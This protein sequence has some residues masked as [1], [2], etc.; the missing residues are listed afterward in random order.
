VVEA[1]Q[2]GG[3]SGQ[4]GPRVAYTVEGIILKHA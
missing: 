2:G 4:L 3:H 1:G